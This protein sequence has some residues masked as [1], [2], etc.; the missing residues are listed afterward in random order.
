MIHP[1]AL[2]APS[3]R[4]LGITETAA[5][6]VNG[7]CIWHTDRE[8]LLLHNADSTE[9]TVM[10]L[11][12]RDYLGRTANIRNYSVPTDSV[13]AISFLGSH[14]VYGWRQCDGKLHLV[15]SSAEI[16]LTVLQTDLP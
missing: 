3:P 2:V 15:A 9:H 4:S 5:D 10:L 14:R 11:G 8:V 12:V 7:N 16:L 13:S 1:S 6:P